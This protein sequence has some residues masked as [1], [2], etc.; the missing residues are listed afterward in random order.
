MPSD[1]RLAKADGAVT[2]AQ[3]A[4]RLYI[5]P[6]F[7]GENFVY[8]GRVRDDALAMTKEVSKRCPGA[9]TV[10]DSRFAADYVLRITRAA[11]TLYQRDGDVAY[12]SPAWRVTSLTK[13]LCAFVQSQPAEPTTAREVRSRIAGT[14][15]T[16]ANYEVV[17]IGMSYD[18]V[19]GIL[20]GGTEI[21]RS[22]L[23]G[24]TTVMYVWRDSTRAK[25]NAM[26]QND[27]LVNKFQFELR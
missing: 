1:S 20:G 21:S 24:Y 11:S 23:A 10:T 8:Y 4:K 5:E 14:A 26:F 6:H 13:D 9:I 12:V 2:T 3:N 16:M 25:M 18:Q 22:E 27:R 15:L 17:R 7:T 19:V